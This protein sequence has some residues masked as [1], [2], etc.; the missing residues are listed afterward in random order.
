MTFVVA[1]IE[2]RVLVK[3]NTCVA[4]RRGRARTLH[5]LVPRRI[6]VRIFNAL[7]LLLLPIEHLI[8]L[9]TLTAHLVR[10][11]LQV[12]WTPFAALLGSVVV[13]IYA[14]TLVRFVVEALQVVSAAEFVV[15]QVCEFLF[16]VLSNTLVFR[17][18]PGA[19]EVFAAFL[20]CFVRR[21][22]RR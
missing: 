8:C 14:G 7:T 20:T 4:V 21:A 17:C 19:G 9:L 18:T 10:S 12:S 13:P 6:V 1:P 11:G 5:T 22:W 16:D 15:K 3:T 2:D